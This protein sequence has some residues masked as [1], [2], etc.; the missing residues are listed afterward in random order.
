MCEI[1]KFGGL[2][3]TTSRQL[4]HMRIQF[5]GNARCLK[6]PFMFLI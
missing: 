2:A 3:L 6:R 4:K 5:Y 1:G